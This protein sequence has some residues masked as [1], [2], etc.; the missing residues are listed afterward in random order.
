M[1]IG[2]VMTSGPEN[3]GTYHYALSVLSALR[4]YAK[5]NEYVLF[6]DSEEFPVGNYSLSNWV[7]V[8]YKKKENFLVKLSRAASLYGLTFLNRYARGRH[9]IIL[10][11]Q[12]DY[13]I[14]LSTS[15]AA[16]W[17]GLKF[18]APIHD[19]WHRRNLPGVKIYSEIFRERIWKKVAV[20][21]NMVLVESEYGRKEVIDAYK[22][23]DDKIYT[24]PTGPAPFIWRN[25]SDDCSQVDVEYDLPSSFVFYPG[26]L[27]AAKNQIRVVQALGVLRKKYGLS[28][29][30]VFTGNPAG[31]PELSQSIFD[32]GVSDLIHFYGLVPNKH[33]ACLYRRALCLTMASYVG[34]TNMPIWEAFVIGCPVI[35]SS[36]GAMSE[37]V[38]LAGLL[39][40]PSDSVTLAAHIYT[41]YSDQDL[42]EQLVEEGKKRAVGLNRDIWSRKFINAVESAFKSSSFEQR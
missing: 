33:M 15:L 28:I 39:F 19:V 9:K 4:D 36:A 2:L 18:V 24:L 21:A 41:I 17:C 38:D 37:Q 1:R 7:A 13:M 3:G 10:E 27:S 8:Q 22:V 23:S 5:Y 11:Y 42:R 34:P 26:G 6:Y 25:I 20:E 40:D 32:E 29:H 14:C 35:S 30:A 31:Y 16:W 12:V